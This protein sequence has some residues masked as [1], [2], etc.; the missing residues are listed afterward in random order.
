[1]WEKKKPK[2]E[3][4]AVLG[5]GAEFNGKMIFE[6]MVRIDGNFEGEIFGQGSLDIGQG[7]VVRANIDVHR[8]YIGGEVEGGI[9]AKEK[10][11]IHATGK[12]CGDVYTPVLIVEEGAFF[13]GRSSMSDAAQKDSFSGKV[14]KKAAS[15]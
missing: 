11:S 10:V 2:E 5:K 9:K 15:E 14:D 1:M 3:L 8:I 4:K 13:D 7:A 6:G 12:L